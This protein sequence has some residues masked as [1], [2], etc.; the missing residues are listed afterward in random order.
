MSATT[1]L[2]F[3]ACRC[4]KALRHSGAHRKPRPPKACEQCL[5]PMPDARPYEYAQRRFCR[6][7]CYFA[8]LRAMPPEQRR[9]LRMKSQRASRAAG[10]CKGCGTFLMSPPMSRELRDAWRE[11]FDREHAS[12]STAAGDAREEVR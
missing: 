8:H 10:E 2:A 3:K 9:G 7:A 4:G 11:R 5:G 6:R 12:C 1:Q